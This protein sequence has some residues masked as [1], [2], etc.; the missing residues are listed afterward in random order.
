MKS[1]K[2]SILIYIIVLLSYT[3]S[4]A[5]GVIIYQND[6]TSINIPYNKLDSIVTY[7]SVEDS[8]IIAPTDQYGITIGHEIDLGLSVNWAGWDFGAT[9]S[10]G[11]GEHYA[12]GELHPRTNN[13]SSE[14]YAYYNNGYI[15]IG[16][17]I[18]GTVYDVVHNTIGNGWRLPTKEDAQELINNCK[19]EAITCDT[20]AGYKVTGPNGNSI[21]FPFNGCYLDNILSHR[22]EHFCYWTGTLNLDNGGQAYMLW[23]NNAAALTVAADTRRAGRCIRPVKTKK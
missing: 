20:I 22:G 10:R 8:S 18:S 16:E 23:N 3:S 6:G 12:W 9:S 21:F 13:F 19:W 1:S 5:Q 11:Y 15:F 14:E 4:S 2:I 7:E 17:N